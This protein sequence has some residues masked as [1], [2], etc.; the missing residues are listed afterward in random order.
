[1]C[2]GESCTQ[3]RYER[4]SRIPQ[5]AEN[6]GKTSFKIDN[7]WRYS[8]SLLLVPLQFFGEIFNTRAQTQL[9][10]SEAGRHRKLGEY[11]T[12]HSLG[13]DCRFVYPIKESV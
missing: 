8:T 9:S 11:Q 4:D 3:V 5:I 12:N 13:E 2:V 1:M 10:D 7:Q 6:R